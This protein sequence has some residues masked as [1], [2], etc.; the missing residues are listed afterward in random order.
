V[1]YERKKKVK[2]EK[3][4]QSKPSQG[5]HASNAYIFICYLEPQLDQ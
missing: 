4:L 1:K 5:F 2:T 3:Q